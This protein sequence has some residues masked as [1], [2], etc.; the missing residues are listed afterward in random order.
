MVSN[1]ALVLDFLFLLYRCRLLFP[2]GRFC[3]YG[4]LVP[5]PDQDW[6]G[7]LV[8]LIRFFSCPSRINHGASFGVQC[9][10]RLHAARPPSGPALATARAADPSWHTARP[11]TPPQKTP[12]KPPLECTLPPCTGRTMYDSPRTAASC[13][14]L[15]SAKREEQEQER[16][17]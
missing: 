6:Y 5:A 12:A 3:G 16:E 8:L 1:G 2:P 13:V 17:M 15:S 9:R 14:V 10:S 4:R 7:D 11:Q